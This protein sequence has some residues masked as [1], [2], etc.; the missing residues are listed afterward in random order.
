MEIK[1]FIGQKLN[2]INGILRVHIELSKPL[3]DKKDLK[4]TYEY[5][6]PPK[7]PLDY[8]SKRYILYPLSSHFNSKRIKDDVVFNISFQHLGDLGYFLNRN[9]TI[10]TCADIYIFIGK[11]KPWFIQKYLISGLKRC[12][13]IMAISDFTKN[14]I[15]KFLGVPE[16]KIIVIKCGI[17]RE[18]FKPIP[19]NKITELTPF[20]PEFRKILHVGTEIGRKDFLTLLK[21]FYI[22]KKKVENIKLIRVGTPSYPKIIKNLG[23]EKD[24]IYL[25][26]ISDKRLIEI[27]NLCDFFVFPSLY[28]GFGLPGLEAAACGIPVICSDIPIFREIYQDFPIYFSQGNYHMLAKIILENIK[29]VSLKEEISKK[30]LEIVKHYSWKK[31]AEKYYNVIKYIIENN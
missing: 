1:T 8:F 4:F 21:A 15:I 25:T 14:E 9:K 22:L 16:E 26:S 18:I 30:G 13:Y 20:Y 10:I 5:Y 27:Y 31:S 2:Y 23:L 3:K 28:E 24:I 11:R 29:N 17:N 19:Q 12:K 6:N 7:N